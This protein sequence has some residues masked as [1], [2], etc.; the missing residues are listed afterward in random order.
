MS[1]CEMSSLQ[2]SPASA[3]Q[4]WARWRKEGDAEPPGPFDDLR[5]IVV[6][7]IRSGAMRPRSVGGWLRSRNLGLDWNRPLDVLRA[8]PEN[9]PPVSRGRVSLRRADS[10]EEGPHA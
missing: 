2:P 3:G 5:E 1:V 8:G 4:P 7:L 6:L 10:G 9:F